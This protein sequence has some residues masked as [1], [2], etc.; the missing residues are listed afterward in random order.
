MF[1]LI[2][3]FQFLKNYF[4]YKLNNITSLNNQNN[5]GTNLIVINPN[6]NDSCSIC[7]QNFNDNETLKLLNCNH[8]FHKN[9]IDEWIKINKNCP[10]CRENL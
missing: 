4:R 5:I 2:F 10:I 1:F 7:L 3:C 9:C 6:Y 8:K